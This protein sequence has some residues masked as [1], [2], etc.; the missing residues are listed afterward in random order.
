[1]RFVLDTNVLRSAITHPDGVNREVLRACLLGRLRPIMGQKLFLE[2]EDVL[3]REQTLRETPLSREEIRTLLDA[4]YS[5]CEWISVWF[6][7]RPNLT[8]E[9]DN[10]LLELAVA[11][12]AEGIITQNTKHL[13]RGELLFP[14]LQI[15]TPKAW[16]ESL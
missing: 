8:D 12:N 13:K 3:F 7:W 14:W 2:I 10:H 5:V 6:L 1:M 9:S 16:K 11:A 4:F 15:T